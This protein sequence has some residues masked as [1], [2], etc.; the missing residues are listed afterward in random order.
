MI[1]ALA[2]LSL[3]ISFHRALA[4]KWR[5]FSVAF[6]A[7]SNFYSASATTET[8]LVSELNAPHG[9]AITSTGGELYVVETDGAL[10]VGF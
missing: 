9:I 6:L 10:L 4:C 2:T 1:Y 3:V 7:L 5:H 8:T